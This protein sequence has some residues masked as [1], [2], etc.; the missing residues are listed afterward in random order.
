MK[1]KLFTWAKNH[2]IFAIVILIV[3]VPI[4]FFSVIA[5]SFYIQVET[6]GNYNLFGPLPRLDI[7]LSDKLAYDFKI[8]HGV[9]D[10]NTIEFYNEEDK[11]LLWKVK[12]FYG[13]ETEKTEYLKF[14]QIQHGNVYQLYPSLGLS[15]GN[16]S[17]KEQTE[18]NEISI[19][20]VQPQP[21]KNGQKILIKIES[22][23]G[24][25]FEQPN[26]LK[27]RVFVFENDK[28]KEK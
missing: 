2:K 27:E 16:L 3:L 8:K 24:H 14:G 21:L 10:A 13:F 11:E 26:C 4:L 5:L 17:Y 18:V 22:Y 23:C 20:G 6:N 7:I 12:F 1:N 19:N 28:F 25:G 15:E 9:W